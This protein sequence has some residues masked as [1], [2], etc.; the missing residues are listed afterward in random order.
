MSSGQRRYRGPKRKLPRRSP[1]AKALESDEFRQR[2]VRPDKVYKR[3]PRHKKP[4]D[5]GEDLE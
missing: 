3:K 5:M 4:L 2:V 1:A